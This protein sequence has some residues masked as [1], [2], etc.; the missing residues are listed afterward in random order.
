MYC[1]GERV[2]YT[3]MVPLQ[4]TISYWYHFIQRA[5]YSMYIVTVPFDEKGYHT[6]VLHTNIQYFIHYRCTWLSLTM[7]LLHS[8]WLK[9][10]NKGCVKPKS[11][12]NA[13]FYVCSANA[14]CHQESLDHQRRLKME[15]VMVFLWN[16]PLLDWLK[17]NGVLEFS[18]IV[19]TSNFRGQKQ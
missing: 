8:K 10:K 3:N 5:M 7:S 1:I 13:A 14:E 12:G 9:P 2:P 19:R 17:M 16:W 4:Y 15:N 11:T 18:Q 6:Y